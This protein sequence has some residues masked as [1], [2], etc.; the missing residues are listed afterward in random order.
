MEHRWGPRVP[1]D[2]DV[3]LERAA[4]GGSPLSGSGHVRDISVSGAFV[5]TDL[6]IPLQAALRITFEAPSPEPVASQSLP[7]FVMRKD[8]TGVGIE[9]SELAPVETI[10]AL[11]DYANSLH[12]PDK[13]EADESRP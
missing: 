11:L 13:P 7:A 6:Q 12:P 1:V 8:S 5:E 9:W 2:I 3:H 10:Q 4:P